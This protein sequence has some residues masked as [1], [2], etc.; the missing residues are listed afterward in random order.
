MNDILGINDKSQ[1]NQRKIKMNLINQINKKIGD[2]FKIDEA[3]SR[4]NIVDDKRLKAY[5]MKPEAVSLF[6]K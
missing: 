4:R 1:D 6:K 2:K 5:F 3:I